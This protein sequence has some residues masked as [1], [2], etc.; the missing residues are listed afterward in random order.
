MAKTTITGVVTEID[1]IETKTDYSSQTFRIMV[2]EFDSESGKPRKPEIF[3]VTIF[4]KK[5]KEMDLAMF[6]NKRVRCVCYL[7]SVAKEKDGK[8]FY[9]LLLNGNSIEEA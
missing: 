5:I 8:T 1:P 3:P 2:Q 7:K 9:N 4:N 6:F